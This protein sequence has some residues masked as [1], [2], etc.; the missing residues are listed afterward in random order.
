MMKKE[1]ICKNKED[2]YLKGLLSNLEKYSMPSKKFE[3][4]LFSSISGAFDL[5]EQKILPAEYTLLER[6]FFEKPWRIVFPL[7]LIV[8]VIFR[9]AAGSI[10]D[11]F[12]FALFAGI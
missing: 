3:A 12:I 10:F 9:L 4:D 8:S 6:I 2:K 5:N 7:S 1:D 11:K